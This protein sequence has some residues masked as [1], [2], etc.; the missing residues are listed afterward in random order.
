MQTEVEARPHHTPI[1]R[2]AF[3]G[4]VLVVAVALALKLV[5]G[6]VIAIFWTVAIIAIVLA[7]LWALKT[8]VW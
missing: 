1:V 3:A 5:I 4:V 6:F 8:L 2:K 7:V